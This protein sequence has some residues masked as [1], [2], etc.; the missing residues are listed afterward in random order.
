MPIFNLSEVINMTNRTTL[1]A[2][3]LLL[4]LGAGNAGATVAAAPDLALEP[5]INGEVSATGDYAFYRDSNDLLLEPAINGEVS[6]N[7]RFASEAEARAY[8]AEH[9]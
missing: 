3:S 6:A 8:V 2:S 9:R 7:G 5:A 4:L 1:I